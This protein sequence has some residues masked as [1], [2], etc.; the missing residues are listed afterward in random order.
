MNG[1]SV[2]TIALLALCV[3]AAGCNA[4]TPAGVTATATVTVTRTTVAPTTV[5]QAPESDPTGEPSADTGPS[6]TG[7]ADSAQDSTIPGLE[8][9]G[10]QVDPCA[11]VTLADAQRLAA[12]KLDPAQKIQQ[13]CTYSGPVS[14]P[15]AQVQVFVGPGSKKQL[16]IERTL[17]HPLRKLGQVRDEAW[18][19]E[20]AVYVRKGQLWVSVELVLLNEPAENAPRLDQLAT[21]VAGRL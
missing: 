3:V 21:V 1:R 14:G 11:L 20:S 8:S 6:E 10:A 15:T 9:E 7:P 4:S 5:F 18:A 16:D 17:G 12:T 2:P 19:G 13:T